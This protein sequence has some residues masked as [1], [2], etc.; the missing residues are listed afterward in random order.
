[1]G[2]WRVKL[3]KVKNSGRDQ[4]HSPSMKIIYFQLNL[5][6]FANA[7]LMFTIYAIKSAQFKHQHC[8]NHCE[9]KFHYRSFLVA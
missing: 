4:Y 3:E 5:F 8:S 6:S 2:G 1:M 9:P 7:S